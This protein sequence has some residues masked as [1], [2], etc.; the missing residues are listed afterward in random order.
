[1]S[2]VGTD[3]NAGIPNA[4]ELIDE[5]AR[6]DEADTNEPSTE[7]ARREGGVVVVVND[8]AHFCIG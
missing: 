3:A 6:S 5:T 4:E 1:M 7:G 2:N 8:S